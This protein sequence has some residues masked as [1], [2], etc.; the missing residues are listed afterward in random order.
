V[1]DAPAPAASE[2]AQT[3]IGALTGYFLIRAADDAL[4]QQIA[5]ASPHMRHGGRVVVRLLGA[6]SIGFTPAMPVTE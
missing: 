3:P 4:A 1:I 5:A 6:P 2:A